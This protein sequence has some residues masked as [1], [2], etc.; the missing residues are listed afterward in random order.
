[1]HPVLYVWH[2]YNFL[3]ANIWGLAPNFLAKNDCLEM[4]GTRPHEK[5]EG[6]RQGTLHQEEEYEQMQAAV[7][8][9]IVI[10]K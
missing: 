9:L 7:S 1:M 5:I 10:L 4:R 6:T 2:L 3:E 8:N